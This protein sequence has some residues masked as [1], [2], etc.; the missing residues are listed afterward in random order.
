MTN[1]LTLNITFLFINILIYSSFFKIHIDK[2]S[3][4]CARCNLFTMALVT[5]M[6]GFFMI[7]HP[8]GCQHKSPI[9]AILARATWTKKMTECFFKYSAEKKWVYRNINWSCWFRQRITG[10]HDN[11]LKSPGADIKQIWILSGHLI[12]NAVC[13]CVC[14][15]SRWISSSASK[16]FSS[17]PFTKCVESIAAM[18]VRKQ[19]VRRVFKKSLIC[20]RS[21][22]PQV[23]THFPPDLLTQSVRRFHKQFCEEINITLPF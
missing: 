4:S 10:F 14:V 19:N 3:G 9:S 22:S 2:K 13:V 15:S 8:S 5:E 12:C 20:L 7:L 1:E 21:A 17:A 6:Y 18:C 16:H 11:C 23:H